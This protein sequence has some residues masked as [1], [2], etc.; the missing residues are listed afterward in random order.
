MSE[1]DSGDMAVEAEPSCQYSITFFLSCDRW[2]QR[3]SLTKWCLIWK[4]MLSKG[5]GI[6]FLYVEKKALIGIH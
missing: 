3:G 1:V 4:H 2:Q 6:K 5:V